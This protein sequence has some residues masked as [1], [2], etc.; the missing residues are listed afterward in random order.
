MH[1]KYDRMRAT[2]K[3]I[4]DV[5]ESCINEP[6]MQDLSL[7]TCGSGISS[8]VTTTGPERAERVEALA[9]DPLRITELDVARADV[10]CNRVPEHS[11]ERIFDR[12][13]SHSTTDHDLKLDFEV[14]L[15]GQLD[16]PLD[17]LTV[18][19]EREWQ[20]AED[21]RILRNR[22]L[23]FVR[24]VEIVQSD[25]DDL[26]RIGARQARAP[27]RAGRAP[28]RSGRVEPQ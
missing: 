4:C 5:F 15:R 24:V 18:S 6:L 3:I 16:I 22:H 13:R 2:E 14:D 26:L 10:V 19:T 25:R 23:R 28:R 9:A 1:D 27:R 20:L 17:W 7:D 12:H 21:K 11:V 8:A